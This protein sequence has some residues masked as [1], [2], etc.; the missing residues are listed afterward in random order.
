M[1]DFNLDTKSAILTVH[2]ESAIDKDDFVKIAK[3]IDPEIE[4]HGDLAGLII[5]APHFPGW[6]SFGA[7][8]NHMRFVR[9]HHKHIKKIAVVTD[10]HFGDAAEHI[11][12]HFVAAEIKHFPAGQADAARAWI[13]GDSA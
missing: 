4:Q 11:A 13:A 5:E 7:L 9:D 3:S 2:P 12:S 1:I 6:D 10:S 8:V